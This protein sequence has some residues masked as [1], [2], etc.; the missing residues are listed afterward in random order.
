MNSL[1]HTKWN[2]IY[3]IVFTE[4]T[5]EK[6]YLHILTFFRKQFYKFKHWGPFSRQIIEEV[7][8]NSPF[9]DVI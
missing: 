2:C 7:T 4:L 6:L 8:P 5:H 3:H 9:K 1:A